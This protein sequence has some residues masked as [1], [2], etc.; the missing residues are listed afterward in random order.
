LDSRW[1]EGRKRLCGYLYEH[2]DKTL[3]V[4]SRTEG[5]NKRKES[6]G[7]TR[8]G[9]NGTSAGDGD[10]F[11]AMANSVDASGLISTKLLSPYRNSAIHK[12]VPVRYSVTAKVSSQFIESY[13]TTT[14]IRTG[15][16]SLR[17]RG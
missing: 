1:V 8:T 10:R 14:I 6:I 9:G 16:F 2:A 7:N 12:R 3:G 11:E 15:R 17:Q 13:P 4:V 5:N